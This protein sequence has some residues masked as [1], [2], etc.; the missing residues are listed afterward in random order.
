M[1]PDLVVTFQLAGLMEVLE[2]WSEVPRPRTASIVKPSN[3]LRC[4][5]I[6][7]AYAR[8]NSSRHQA[9][10]DSYREWPEGHANIT[11]LRRVG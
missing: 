4:P 8:V 3:A 9:K 7:R 11:A 5:G 6:T 1:T 2:W 10:L